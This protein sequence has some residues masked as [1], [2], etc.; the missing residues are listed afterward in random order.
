MIKTC[1]KCKTPFLATIQY[2]YGNKAG[3]FGLKAHCKPCERADRREYS[4]VNSEKI[5]ARKRKYRAKN[6]KKISEAAHRYY[7]NK[8][9]KG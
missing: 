5:K 3:T 2:F 8:V 6:S 7:I 4:L 9:K 1:T